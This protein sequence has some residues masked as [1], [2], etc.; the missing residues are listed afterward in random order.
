MTQQPD[1]LENLRANFI[2]Q[3]PE[4]TFRLHTYKYI[5]NV[6]GWDREVTRTLPFRNNDVNKYTEWLD[7][8]TTHIKTRTSSRVINSEESQRDPYYNLFI[9]E[10]DF[11]EQRKCQEVS[12][13]IERKLQ[14]RI[15]KKKKISK[16]DVPDKHKPKKHK[17][18]D[19]FSKYKMTLEEEMKE[20]EKQ[21][22]INSTATPLPPLAKLK[23]D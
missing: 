10:T 19:N 21:Y 16:H 13:E 6:F 14:E 18:K 15:T 20:Q 9:A 4:I 3:H 11:E 5:V 8:I 2:K 23:K 1:T 7:Y 17:T 12:K 22:L